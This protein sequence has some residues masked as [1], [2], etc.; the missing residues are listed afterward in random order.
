MQGQKSQLSMSLTA[1][2]GCPPHGPAGRGGEIPENRGRGKIKC[3]S[4]SKTMFLR[5]PG[6]HPLSVIPTVQGRAI[7]Q[8]RDGDCLS[9]MGKMIMLISSKSPSQE[10]FLISFTFQKGTKSDL[11]S[12]FPIFKLLGK[13]REKGSKI[14]TSM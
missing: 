12:S 7:F 13:K 3:N 10:Q 1:K 2:T 14:R 8:Y 5:W 4:F 11:P 6:S 9:A